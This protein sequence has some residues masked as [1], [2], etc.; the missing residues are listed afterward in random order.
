[1]IHIHELKLLNTIQES[2]DVITYIFEKP[3]IEW[4]EG[5]NVH[6]A[7]H[8]FEAYEKTYVRHLSVTTLTTEDDFRFT[9]RLSSSP[10]KEKLNNLKIGDTMLFFKFNARIPLETGRS[11]VLLSMG[12]GLAAYQTLMKTIS[13]EGSTNDIK[14]ITVAKEDLFLDSIRAMGIDHS[15]TRNRKDYHHLIESTYNK[16]AIYYIVGSDDFLEDN[17]RFLKDKNH[18]S[19]LIKIDKKENKR[20]LYAI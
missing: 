19:E 15:I 17:I 2:H 13:N 6:V 3:G 16:D 20:E 9:T 4:S 10:F 8:D 14:S 11:I 18:T 5:T 12:V 7:F 1:M